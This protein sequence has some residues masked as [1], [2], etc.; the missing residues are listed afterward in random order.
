MADSGVDTGNESSDNT[1]FDHSHQ[2]FEF[3]LPPIPISIAGMPMP[4]DFFGEGHD[5]IGKIKFCTNARHCRRKYRHNILSSCYKNKKLRFAAGTNNPEEVERLL[6]AGADPNFT[7]KLL[8]SPLHLAAC[9][10]YTEVVKILIQYGANPNIKDKLGNTPLHLAAC[11]SNISVVT[12]LL[13]AGTDVSSNDKNGRTPL[14]LAQSKLKLI[15]MRSG[16]HA[17]QELLSEIR[18]IVEMML[19]YMEIQKADSVELESVCK[20]LENISTREQVDSEVQNL[21]DNLDS[22]Q[23]R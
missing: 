9:R 13:G 2:V 12:A 10:G 6:Q 4:I 22:L 5:H 21:L 1:V 3:S 23:L 8:R 7:D 19:K 18:Q 16:F 20:R 11:T 14:Q 17:T 15:K